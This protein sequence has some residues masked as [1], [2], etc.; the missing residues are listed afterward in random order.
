M[1]RCAPWARGRLDRGTRVVQRCALHAAELLAA[2]DGLIHAQHIVPDRL[3]Q[4]S[5][6][7]PAHIQAQDRGDGRASGCVTGTCTGQS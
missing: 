3:R 5:A 4:R 1:K 2:A 7:H 6:K